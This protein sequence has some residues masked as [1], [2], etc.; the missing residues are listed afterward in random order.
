MPN[1]PKAQYESHNITA[2]TPNIKPAV[3]N[4]FFFPRIFT[5]LAKP[6]AV[7]PKITPE[8]YMQKYNGSKLGVESE[9]TKVK[10]IKDVQIA[11]AM[12]HIKETVL[13]FLILLLISFIFRAF[14]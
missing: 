13:N 1:N 12:P 9:V 6:I 2:A 7:T 5:A 3:D 14:N 11:P 10:F 4:L 8:K